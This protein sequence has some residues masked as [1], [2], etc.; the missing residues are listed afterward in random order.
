[1]VWSQGFCPPKLWPD[2]LHADDGINFTFQAILG[3]QK[4]DTVWKPRF[5]VPV[6]V[7]TSKSP[8][9]SAGFSKPFSFLICEMWVVISD[10]VARRIK[11][12]S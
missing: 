8:W 9:T 11:T 10:W 12:T 6:P 3:P 4:E 1:M 2:G 5:W 7:H